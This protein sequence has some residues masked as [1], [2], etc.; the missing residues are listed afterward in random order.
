[1]PRRIH[2]RWAEDRRRRRY[3]P[4]ADRTPTQSRRARACP[5]RS[6]GELHARTILGRDREAPRIGDCFLVLTEDE[7]LLSE[8]ADVAARHIRL[9][10]GALATAGYIGD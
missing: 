2:L 4:P 8:P 7:A 1:M 6:S 10:T 5:S 3:T 9:F